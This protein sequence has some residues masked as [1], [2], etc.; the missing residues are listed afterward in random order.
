MWYDTDLNWNCAGESSFGI[1]IRKTSNLFTDNAIKVR[2]GL[3]KEYSDLI[4][5]VAEWIFCGAWLGGRQKRVSLLGHKIEFSVSSHINQLL[6]A[7]FHLMSCFC[8]FVSLFSR[9]HGAARHVQSFSVTFSCA[10][11]NWVF[12]SCTPGCAG[13]NVSAVSIEIQ[14]ISKSLQ[15]ETDTALQL[16]LHSRIK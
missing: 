12:F 5:M 13:M 10:L 4:K 15:K 1:K 2:S 8:H 14:C 11:S 6:S 3:E 16:F 7:I 9:M